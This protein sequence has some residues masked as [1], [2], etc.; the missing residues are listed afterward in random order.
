MTPA[1]MSREFLD[2]AQRKQSSSDPDIATAETVELMCQHANRS[3]SNPLVIATARDVAARYRGG[4]L[5]KGQPNEAHAIANS[6][7]WF[8]KTNLE[9]IHHEDMIRALWNEPGQ[10]QLLIAPDV[11]LQTPRPAGDCAVYTMLVCALLKVNG[12]PFEVVTVA[13]DPGQPSMFTH[14]YARAVLPYGARAPLDAS[15]GQYPGWE[16][17][18]AHVTRKQVWDESGRPIEDVA[19]WNGLHGYTRRGLGM[20]CDGTDP[21]GTCTTVNI[22]G[23][24]AS[25]SGSSWTSF[26]QG[27]LN[28]GINLAGRVFAP[29]T[30]YQRGPN[31]QVLLQ[32]PGSAPVFG[33]D[34]LTS[35]TG[36]IP[37]WVW[38]AGAGVLAVMLFKGKR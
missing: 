33:A 35:T 21:L 5:Y 25:S 32:T 37:S 23:A 26:L 19:R 7:W 9:F 2:R 31:G 28:Q 38:I 27:A 16:V 13:C 15:H 10:L 12:V 18:R 36:E 20:S 6:V 1:V 29:Q 4:P 24:P 22:P 14:V 30:T 17:P 34:L 3:A 8:C 11:L